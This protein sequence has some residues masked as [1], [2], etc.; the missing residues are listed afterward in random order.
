MP[1]FVLRKEDLH[2]LTNEYP[3]PSP[4]SSYYDIGQIQSFD[5]TRSNFELLLDDKFDPW[6]DGYSAGKLR[7]ENK[8]AYL[9]KEEGQE[10]NRFYYLLE[11]ENGD[12]YVAYGWEGQNIRYIFK[13]KERL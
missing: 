10:Y 7:E 2:L 6:A 11:Q 3:K 13:M 9:V 8:N 4:L 1:I 12:V 5:L